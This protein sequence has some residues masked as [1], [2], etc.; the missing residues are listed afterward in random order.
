MPAGQD[1]PAVAAGEAR[2]LLLVA[3]ARLPGLR[4]RAALPVEGPGQQSG[5]HRK[6]LSGAPARPPPARTLER[7]GPAS[8]PASPLAF[9]GLPRRGE[10]L[11]RPRARRPP[12]PAEH[13]DP[14]ISHRGG[15]QPQAAGHRFRPSIRPGA[16]CLCSPVVRKRR[17]RKIHASPRLTPIRDFPRTFFN[18]PRVHWMRNALAH[19]PT[20]QRAAVAAMLK[21]IFAQETRAEAV[22]Q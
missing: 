1:P 11:A 17:G 2:P 7:G 13:A 3:G 20:K 8:L 21:T 4:P 22:A 5:R 15:H 18:S 9:R 6:R 14:G 10:D 12:R 19:A 16:G